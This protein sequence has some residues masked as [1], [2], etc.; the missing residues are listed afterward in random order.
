VKKLLWALCAGALLQACGG[1]SGPAPQPPD[2]GAPQSCSVDAQ[3]GSLDAW[4]KDRYY[5][6]H[7]GGVPNPVAADLPGYFD[8][9]LARPADRYSFAQSTESFDQLFNIGWRYGFGYVLAWDV[10]TKAL[11]VRNVEPQSPAAAAGLRRGDFIVTVDGYTAAQVMDGANPAVNEAGVDRHF[12]VRGSDGAQREITVRSAMFPLTPMA[13]SK[14]LDGTRAG[15]GVRVGYLAYHQFTDYS[16]WDVA[17]AVRDL[18]SQGVSEMVLDLRYNGGGS[19]RSSRNLASFL[20]GSRTDGAV[21]AHL[22]YNDQH[23]E[24]DQDIRFTTTAERL[25]PAIEGL[26]RVIVLTSG[27][28]ASASELL[29]N[30]L[31]PFVPVVLVGETTYGKPYGFNPRSECGVTYNAVNFEVVNA[32]GTAGYANGMP[33]DCAAP[34]DFDHA[35]GDPKE[36]RLAAALDYIATGRC[37]AQAPQAAALTPAKRPRAYGETVP[38][39]MFAVP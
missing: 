38:A 27:G 7:D 4:M 22:K 12:V 33:A 1:G 3:R 23:P 29:V 31:R 5:W 10:A 15:Q 8:S 19:V 21:F 14:V 18:A 36:R 20:G 6:Y 17:I 32:L 13:T 37:S 11:R 35:L 34:D 9:M 39:Q 28:T 2:P 26:Q 16:F 30:G 24:L 25:T